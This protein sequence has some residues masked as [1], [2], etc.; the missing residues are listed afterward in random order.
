MEPVDFTVQYKGKEC[1]Y[2]ASFRRYGYT[3]RIQ[4][5]IEDMPVDFEPDEEGQ[6]RAILNEPDSPA[7]RT[8]DA[9]LL[10]TIAEELQAALK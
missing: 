1:Q 6:F 5:N 7:Y 10:Q 4:V 2:Q 9:R 3:Y 8:M